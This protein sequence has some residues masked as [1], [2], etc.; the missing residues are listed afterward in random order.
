MTLISNAPHYSRMCAVWIRRTFI[1]II[2]EEGPSISWLRA[3]HIGFVVDKVAL[4]QVSLREFL[5]SPVS[6]VPF[7]SHCKYINSARESVVKQHT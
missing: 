2:Y 7:L 5:L 1:H 3:V 6:D 4:R